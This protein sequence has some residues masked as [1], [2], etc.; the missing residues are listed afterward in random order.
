MLVLNV[1][2]CSYMGFDSSLKCKIYVLHDLKLEFCFLPNKRQT[3]SF[4]LPLLTLGSS[5][6]NS[7]LLLGII[8]GV[9]VDEGF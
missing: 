7:P 8:L 1:V 3:P 9:K 2:E 5:I 4:C 6:P